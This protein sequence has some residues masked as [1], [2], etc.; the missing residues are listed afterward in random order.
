LNETYGGTLKAYRAFLFFIQRI[1]FIL[2][3][4]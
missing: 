2:N 3:I 4:S 1:M